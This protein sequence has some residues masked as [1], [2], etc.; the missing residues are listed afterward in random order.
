MTNYFIG[1]DGGGTKTD[2]LCADEQG[3]IVGQ[4]TAGPTNLTSTSVGAASFNLIEALRQA[5]QSL[6]QGSPGHDWM[7]GQLVMGLAGMDTL[8]EQRRAQEIFA[9]ALEPYAVQRLILV[10]DSIIAMENA[11]DSPQAIVLISGTGTICFGRNETGQTAKTSGVD[12]LL[13]DQGSGYYIGSYVLREAVKSYDGRRPKTLLE[14]LVAAHFRLNSLEYLK[15]KVYNPLLSK[16]E[17]AELSRLCFTALQQGDEA[18][19]LI[20]SRTVEEL[21]LQAETVIKKLALTDKP[22]ECVFA[23]SILGLPEVRDAVL[24]KL[25]ASCSQ[26]TPRIPEKPP[27][28]GALKMALKKTDA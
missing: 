15:E 26:L 11:T 13:G 21:V 2:V 16:V 24:A 4:A 7:I 12:F 8:A 10:N 23:G 14:S 1:V 17:I 22:F 5:M 6:P 19:Q 3:T 18:A 27:V 25:Q 9:R 20:V 28:H